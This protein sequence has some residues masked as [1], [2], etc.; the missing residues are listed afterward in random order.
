MVLIFIHL[1]IAAYALGEA[2]DAAQQLRVNT[3]RTLVFASIALVHGI[4]PAIGAPWYHR[5][6][7]P[8]AV[9]MEAAGFALIATLLLGQGWRFYDYIRPAR[10]EISSFDFLKHPT[11]QR[12]LNMLLVATGVIGVFA[13]IGSVYASG[14]TLF[15]LLQSGRLE[16]RMEGAGIV[17]GLTTNLMCAAFVPGFLASFLK[18]RYRTLGLLYGLV[19]AIGLFVLSRGTRAG[20]IGMFG[21][22]ICGVMLAHRLSAARLFTAVGTLC[23]VGMLAVGMLPLRHRM[24]SMSYGEMAQFMFSSEAYQDALTQDPMNYHDHFVAIVGIFPDQF[25]YVHGATY[26]RIAFFYLPGNSFRELKPVDPNRIVA[27]ALFGS[28]ADE[29]DWMHPPGIFGD[30][31]INFWGW[32]GLPWMFIE[33][34][35]LAWISRQIGK[36]PFW[37]LAIGPQMMFLTL[38]GIRGQPYTIFLTMLFSLSVMYVLMRVIGIPR[39]IILINRPSVQ[40]LPSQPSR[41]LRGDRIPA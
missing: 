24:G 32:Y 37:L 8:F 10:Y 5:T 14:A 36:S 34:L 29:V 3:L 1:T 15:T 16:L 27:Q 33:G 21:S 12:K 13:W 20:S 38:I 11:M 18:G 30:C 19:F 31:Y 17:G 40:T 28:I 2:W 35:G 39:T 41:V 6:P 7:D 4:V 26:R 25:D 23:L 9:H 22:L